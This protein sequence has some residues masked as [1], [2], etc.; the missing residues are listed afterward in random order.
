MLFKN[1]TE[2]QYLLLAAAGN[3]L[4]GIVGLVVAF[5]SDSEAI[6]LDGLFNLTYFVSSLFA[7]KI[8]ALLAAGDNDKYPL[9]YGYFEPLING[10]KGVL[11]FGV[12]LMALFS[13]L[14]ALFDGGRVVDPEL[15]VGYGA[16]ATL[17][18]WLVFAFTHVGHKYTDS[19]LV[20]TDKENWLIN[21][22][23]SSCVL[24]A[25]AGIHLLNTLGL[26]EYAPYVDPVVVLT[27]VVIS[28]PVP[29]KMAKY[30]VLQL[31][32]RTPDVHLVDSAKTEI[33]ETLDGLDV[34]ALYVR[35]LQPGRSR[36]VIAQAVVAPTA[37]L[38]LAQQDKLR[39]NAYQ[40][41]NQAHPHTTLD[42]TFTFDSGWGLPKSQGGYFG[43]AS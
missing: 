43:L 19:P 10:L 39:L 9:G 2:R 38:S 23:I 27:V 4:V 7:I 18:G 42:L 35:V 37:D 3:L 31:L 33:V 15:A 25:F 40:K 41:L 17:I 11:V 30:A 13:S 6:L 16:F 21:A 1:L 32:N 12:A 5:A 14:F 24:V 34:Q 8:A 26:P 36:M 20:K 28:L 29:Y 22:L